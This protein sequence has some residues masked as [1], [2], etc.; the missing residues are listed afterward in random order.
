MHFRHPV[1]I[2]G[3]DIHLFRLFFPLD[4][5]ARK[6]KTQLF[7]LSLEL[8]RSIVDI[9]RLF[10]HEI[11]SRELAMVQI[12][13]SVENQPSC[14]YFDESCT[15]SICPDAVALL[16]YLLADTLDIMVTLV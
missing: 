7:C 16:R 1:C 13:S 4:S 9:I 2:R 12:M 8:N 5:S 11:Y 15:N 6:S 3:M 14:Q 10:D